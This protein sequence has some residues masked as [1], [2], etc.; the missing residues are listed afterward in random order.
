M[1]NQNCSERENKEEKEKKKKNTL[2]HLIFFWGQVTGEEPKHLSQKLK[3]RLFL[4][5]CSRCLNI[6][7]HGECS[8][9]KGEVEQPNV[10]SHEASKYFYFLQKHLEAK[11]QKLLEMKKGVCEVQTASQLFLFYQ[12]TVFTGKKFST[13]RQ[14]LKFQFTNFNLIFRVLP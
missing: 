14:R 5:Q 7:Q 13:S 10:S 6:L 9:Q 12:Q 2:R 4:P 8:Q 3:C 1:W 11:K